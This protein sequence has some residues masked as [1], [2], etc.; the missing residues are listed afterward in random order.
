MATSRIGSSA[1]AVIT[2]SAIIIFTLF[3]LSPEVPKHFKEV[4]Q[5]TEGCTK[6]IIYPQEFHD[7]RCQLDQVNLNELL[8]ANPSQ[9]NEDNIQAFL[10]RRMVT[11]CKYIKPFGGFYYSLCKG[12]DGHKYVCV[13]K[14]LEDVKNKRCLIYSFGVREDWTFES[15][16][17]ALG[18][19]VH[20]YDPTVDLSER[21][22][23]FKFYKIGVG[24]V[25]TKRDRTLGNLIKANGH[26]D[27]HITMIKMDVDGEEVKGLNKWLDEGSLDN[28]QQ[29]AL[30]YHLNDKS[31]K[32]QRSFVS[33]VQKL[34][35]LGFRTI[36]WE[37][38]L[39]YTQPSINQL[40][41]NVFFPLVA[42]IVWARIPKGY[43]VSED[44][45]F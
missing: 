13:E 29:F 23:P 31:L 36:S 34:Y 5:D 30:E 25:D 4:A 2:V 40:G 1:S 17:S 26:R 35:R 33:A 28:V 7:Q 39:C 44:C 24:H 11:P 43:N 16:V 10:Q 20:A 42:E 18:C 45:G 14:L 27:R 15:A 19:E 21:K 37:A 22:I 8:S 38:N 9:M 41:S 32:I 6:E 12:Y 3:Y